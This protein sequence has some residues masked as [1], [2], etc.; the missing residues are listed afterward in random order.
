MTP[1]V[2]FGLAALGTAGVATSAYYGVGL[3]VGKP[4]V[5]REDAMPSWR[6]L[7]KDAEFSQSTQPSEA[8]NGKYGADNARFLVGTG[9]D[10]ASAEP[11]SNQ[12]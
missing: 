5:N 8:F 9:A 4:K 1:P 7:D 3:F 11:T 10:V 12:D 2:K 6:P